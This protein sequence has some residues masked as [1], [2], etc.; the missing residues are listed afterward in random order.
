MHLLLQLGRDG[1]LVLL[2]GELIRLVREMLQLLHGGVLL[3]HG[4]VEFR[5]NEEGILGECKHL[6][7]QLA[8]GELR[9][10]ERL[11]ERLLCRHVRRLERTQLADKCGELTRIGG[12]YAETARLWLVR[13]GV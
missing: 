3:L 12:Q 10:Q 6:P 4:I 13:I 11:R 5:L 9:R 8:H 7:L 1:G 2:C